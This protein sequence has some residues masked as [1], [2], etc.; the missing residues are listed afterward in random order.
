MLDGTYEVSAR[1]LFHTVSGLVNVTTQGN[2]ITAQVNVLGKDLY[3]TGTC[4]GDEFKFEGDSD[5]PFGH[6]DY[7]MVGRVDGDDMTVTCKTKLATFN[8]KGV[9][10]A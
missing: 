3:A 10:K 1:V 2:T 8:I 5:T 7:S 4:E 9:R 6:M